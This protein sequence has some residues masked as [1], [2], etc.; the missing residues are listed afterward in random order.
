M[1][2]TLRVGKKAQDDKRTVI[3]NEVKNLIFPCKILRKAAQDDK[4]PL[5]SFAKKAQDDKVTTR[6]LR[7]TLRFAKKLR[8]TKGSKDPCEAH[9]VSQKRFRMTRTERILITRRVLRKTAQDD[10]KKMGIKRGDDGN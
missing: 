1:R 6:S 5:R 8:M 10:R 3:L 4:S 7:S 2:S 9:F